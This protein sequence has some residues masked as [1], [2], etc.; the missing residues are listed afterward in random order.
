MSSKPD[1]DLAAGALARGAGCRRG[2]ARRG[3]GVVATAI[4]TVVR[5]GAHALAAAQHLHLIDADFG[6]VTVLARLR[7][8]PFAG[9]DAAFD[10]NLAAFAQV[11]ARDLGQTTVEDQPVP[12][13]VLA[14]LAALLVLPLVSGGDAV[15]VAWPRPDRPGAQSVDTS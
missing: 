4:A 8:L 13:G 1:D 7:V 14:W 15:R 10:V 2:A 3:G 11:L 9:A 6:A 5:G 12:L